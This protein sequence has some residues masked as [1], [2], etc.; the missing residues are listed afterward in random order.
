MLCYPG[1]AC[2]MQSFRKGLGTARRDKNKSWSQDITEDLKQEIREAFDLFDTAGSGKL[3]EII[4]VDEDFMK[5]S[6]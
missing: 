4:P 2:V 3:H 5:Q 6:I 1:V